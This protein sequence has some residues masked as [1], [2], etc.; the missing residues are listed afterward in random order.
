MG[1][2]LYRTLH[3]GGQVRSRMAGVIEMLCRKRR[4]DDACRKDNSGF[5]YAGSPATF[6]RQTGSTLHPACEQYMVI[7]ED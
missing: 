7:G 4:E 5:R 1:V 2:G 6:R 3:P